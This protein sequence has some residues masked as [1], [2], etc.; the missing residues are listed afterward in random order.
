MLCPTQHI[1]AYTKIIYLKKKKLPKNEREKNKQIC[2]LIYHC[3]E[4]HNNDSLKHVFIFFLS[5]SLSSFFAGFSNESFYSVNEFYDP[6]G[7]K[8]N[9]NDDD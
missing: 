2:H 5:F 6:K 1:Y 7:T 3:V 4:S 9:D 8:I